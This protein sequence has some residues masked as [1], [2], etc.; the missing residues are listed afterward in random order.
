MAHSIDKN[1]AEF[2]TV[3]G[4]VVGTGYVAEDH[5]EDRA[6]HSAIAETQESGVASLWLLFYAAIIC[7]SLFAEAGTGKWVNTA[8]L[9]AQH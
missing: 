5:A 1:P 2:F 4:S 3:V 8:V 7:I 9:L 6:H